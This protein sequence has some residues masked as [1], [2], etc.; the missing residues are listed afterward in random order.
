MPTVPSIRLPYQVFLT[1]AGDG[2][3]RLFVVDQVGQIR[4][5]KNGALLATPFLDLTSKIVTINAFF[6]ERGVLGLAFH[7][8]YANNGRFFV[9]YSAPRTGA[10]TDPCFYPGFVNGCHEEILAEYSVFGGPADPNVA[11][12]NSEIILFRVDEPEFNH[13]A[14]QVMFGPDGLLYWTLGDGGGGNDALH[15]NGLCDAGRCTDNSVC[16]H[17]R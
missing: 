13:D 2:S 11:D 17:P 9:R 8:D 6:D 7:P 12:P 15:R 3:G 5:I 1:H 10:P 4:I 16:S 14:G